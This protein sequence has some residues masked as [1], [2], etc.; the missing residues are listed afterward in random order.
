MAV[1]RV[2]VL[3]WVLY[4]FANTVFSYVVLTRYFTEWVVIERGRPDWVIGVMSVCVAAALVVSLPFFGALADRIGR[5]KPFLTVFTV[6]SVA[7]T[8]LLGAVDHVTLALVVAGVAI[9][10]FNSAEAQYHPLLASVAAPE[11]Q[12]RVSGVAVGVGY[13]GALVALLALGR[14]VEDGENQRAFL[15]AAVLFGTFALPCLLFVRE[16]G[17]ER[18]AVAP[19]TGSLAKLPQEAFAQLLRSVRAARGRPDGRFLIARFFYVDAIATV[20]AFMTVYARRTGGFS[21]PEL[22]TLLALATVFA[23]LGAFVAG[24]LSER[25]GPKR[26]VIATLLAVTATLLLTGLSGSAAILW[27]AGPVVGAALGS[28]T[29]SDR[30]WMLRLVPPE[31]RGEGFGLYALVGKVSNGF[32][33]LVLWGGTIYVFSE[34]LAVATPFD[35]SRVAIGVLAG[36]ALLGAWILRRVP[37]RVAPQEPAVY[38]GRVGRTAAPW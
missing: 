8:A 31:R 6:V 7:G 1:T 28:V 20:I 17:G 9:F 34:A 24:V 30:V 32:G 22:T 5:H 35:A 18:R 27:F 25:F 13:V 23:I 15:P 38:A 10:A 3:S 37:E 33:P 36:A 29:A 26:V 12:S 19:P 11:R 14:L 16:G 4:D 21:A 2:P